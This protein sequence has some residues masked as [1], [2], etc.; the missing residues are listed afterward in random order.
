MTTDRHVPGRGFADLPSQRHTCSSKHMDTSGN[1]SFGRIWSVL[2][3]KDPIMATKRSMYMGKQACAQAS[4]LVSCRP[5][6]AK[7]LDKSIRH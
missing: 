6:E 4:A 3:H 1:G 7:P 5:A 2:Q